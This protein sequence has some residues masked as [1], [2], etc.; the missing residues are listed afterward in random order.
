M[1]DIR[2]ALAAYTAGRGDKRA[3]EQRLALMFAKLPR[4]CAARDAAKSTSDAQKQVA[5]TAV[6]AAQ[7][8]LTVEASLGAL[9]GN[10][11]TSVSDVTLLKDTCWQEAEALATRGAAWSRAVGAAPGAEGPQR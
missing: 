5:Q 2:V 9:R 3:Q 4:D 7:L 11:Q 1:Q 6:V 8:A 10:L